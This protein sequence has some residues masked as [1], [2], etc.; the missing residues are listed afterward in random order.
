MLQKHAMPS[1]EDG[2]WEPQK[3]DTGKTYWINHSLQATAWEPP[4]GSL[5]LCVVAGVESLCIW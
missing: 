3:D 2:I 4:K 5:C 1:A